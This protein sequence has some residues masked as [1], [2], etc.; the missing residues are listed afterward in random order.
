MLEFI[1]EETLDEG[2]EERT[3]SLLVMG[4]SKVGKSVFIQS[5]QS[6]EIPYL[7]TYISTVGVDFRSLLYTFYDTE[8]YTLHKMKLHV[9]DTSGHER[10]YTIRR[11]YYQA[12]EG[13]LVMFDLTQRSTFTKAIELLEEFTQSQE[14]R[15]PIPIFLIGTKRDLAYPDLYHG[16]SLHYSFENNCQV[17]YSEIK[18]IKKKYNLEYYEH[19]V[20]DANCGSFNMDLLFL[21]SD[22][23]MKKMLTFLYQHDTSRETQHS[24]LSSL[25]FPWSSTKS[26][27]KKVDIHHNNDDEEREIVDVTFIKHPR[28]SS[29]CTLL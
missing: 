14:M 28:H 13:L 16:R 8:E 26:Y 29:Y 7:N 6:H 27:K 12:C 19:S 25:F 20:Y 4:T 9:W 23:I 2:N 17:L 10:F 24:F 5:I 18:T 15:L 21:S 11:N 1:D 3:F 22:Q